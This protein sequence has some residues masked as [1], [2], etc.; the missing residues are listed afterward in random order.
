MNRSVLQ[1]TFKKYTLVVFNNT[2][3]SFLINIFIKLRSMW[4]CFKRLYLP[5]RSRSI[6]IFGLQFAVNIAIHF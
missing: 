6:T 5:N 3:I 4:C 2:F 1:N